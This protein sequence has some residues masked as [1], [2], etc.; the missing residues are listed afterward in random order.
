MSKSAIKSS[1]RLLYSEET[2]PR[3]TK[4]ESLL[5]AIAENAEE[6]D[7]DSVPI[8]T[9]QTPQEQSPLIKMNKKL[10]S[11]KQPRLSNSFKYDFLSPQNRDSRETEIQGLNSVVVSP[12][13]SNKSLEDE[14]DED[15]EN[16]FVA[17][18]PKHHKPGSSLAKMLP[19]LAKLGTE[20]RA[21]H[22]SSLKKHSALGSH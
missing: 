17:E 18:L 1:T 21:K 13:G 6:K 14:D 3:V 20:F 12:F 5:D 2:R 7:I 22:G 15:G 4:H 10:S 11:K 16:D 9:F 19:T 8:S